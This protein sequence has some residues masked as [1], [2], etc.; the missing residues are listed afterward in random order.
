MVAIQITD[1]RYL[2]V[3]NNKLYVTY[4][5]ILKLIEQQLKDI[6]FYT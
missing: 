5:I 6:V 2:T 1:N 4:N 3:I